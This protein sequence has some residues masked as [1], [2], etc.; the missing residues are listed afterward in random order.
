[1][2]QRCYC[3]LPLLLVVAGDGLPLV[4]CRCSG[5]GVTMVGLVVWFSVLME[6]QRWWWC[7][8]FLGG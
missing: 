8:V 2:F 4:G 3:G 1:M 5:F 6:L 7:L